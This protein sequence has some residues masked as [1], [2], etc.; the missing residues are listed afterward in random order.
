MGE[1]VEDETDDSAVSETAAGRKRDRSQIEFPYSDLE[2]SIE[3]ATV[4]L[5]EGGQAKI[6]QT[7]LAVA[8][9]QSATGGTFRGRLGAA[10]MFGLIETDAG[11][12]GLTQLGL[13]VTDQQS[14]AAAKAEAFL[15]IPLYKAMFDR[16]QGYALP[17]PAAIERQMESL[18][19]PPKQKER[20]RQAFS[21]SAQHAG[22]IAANGRFSKPTLTG[23]RAKEELPADQVDNG[24]GGA[25]GSGGNGGGIG[26]ENAGQQRVEPGKA[27]EYQLIDLMTE[28]DIDDNVKQSIWALVQYLTARKM[29]KA[30]ASKDT[31]AS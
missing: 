5:R 15:K 4:L 3:L 12:V 18:G 11:R 14:S 20:A 16:Y 8:M 6:D 1:P 10:R 17:P 9:D 25:G 19:V 21:A 23:V 30:T 31:A 2:R 26:S 24:S 22:Y 7:Q 29:K 13:Q 27:L 28:P